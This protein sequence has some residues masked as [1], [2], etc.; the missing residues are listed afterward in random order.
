MKRETSSKPTRR[1][2][3]VAQA[4]Q[5]DVAG[6]RLV[7]GVDRAL[8]GRI[9]RDEDNPVRQAAVDVATRYL[10]LLPTADIIVLI[11]VLTKYASVSPGII[12][13]GPPPGADSA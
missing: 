12:D 1:R 9:Q 5:G 13:P 3:K 6:L 4:A 8:S 10:R 7:G 11:P 2:R